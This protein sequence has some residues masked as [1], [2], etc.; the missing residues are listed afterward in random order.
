VGAVARRRAGGRDATTGALLVPTCGFPRRCL[1]WRLGCAVPPARCTPRSAPSSTSSAP[2]PRQPDHRGAVVLVGGRPGAV[3][4]AA[5]AGTRGA[6]AARPLP[7][8]AQPAAASTTPWSARALGRLLAAA[9]TRRGAPGYL[10]LDGVVVGKAFAKRRRWAGWTY[11]FAKRRKVDGVHAVVVLWCSADR[12]YRIPVAFGLWRP[13]R[14]A[15]RGLPD[16]V[17]AGGCDADRAG[18]R[19][20]AVRLPGWWHP[21]HRGLVHR[22]G[23]PA[24]RYLGGH[25]A[26]ADHRGVARPAL[27]GGRVGRAA[28]AQVAPAAWSAGRP[29]QVYAPRYGTIGLV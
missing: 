27:A 2:P 15:P 29:G 8:R 7:R 23:R 16:Q 18:R 10:C 24:R 21:L 3:G 19:P 12:R 20:P 4:R 6:P 9:V 28:A 26:A 25:A 11:S 5:H 17:A 1:R 14:T 22:S 13:K